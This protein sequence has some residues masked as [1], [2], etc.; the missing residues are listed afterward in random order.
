MYRANA[1]DYRKMCNSLF[2]GKGK[3]DE[4]LTVCTKQIIEF[5]RPCKNARAAMGQLGIVIKEW[6]K[7]GAVYRVR[8]VFDSGENAGEE[9]SVSE[10]EGIAH[11]LYGGICGPVIVEG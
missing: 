10:L 4:Y 3:T 7:D 11:Y 9:L 2:Y 8:L 1:I 5:L 6:E